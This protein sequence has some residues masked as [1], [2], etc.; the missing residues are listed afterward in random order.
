M[1]GIPCLDV[2]DVRDS[3]GRQSRSDNDSVGSHNEK[4]TER[5]KALRPYE[6]SSCTAE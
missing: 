1:T 3:V 4:T 2:W 5:E 6:C